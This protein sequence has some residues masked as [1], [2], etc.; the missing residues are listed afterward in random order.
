[1]LTISEK[2]LLDRSIM[3]AIKVNRDEIQGL[4]YIRIPMVVAPFLTVSGSDMMNH[5][6]NDMRQEIKLLHAR[7]DLRWSYPALRFSSMR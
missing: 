3:E 1:M 5:N 4:M 6:M 2:G 7:F